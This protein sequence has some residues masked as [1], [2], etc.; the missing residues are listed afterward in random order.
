M[1]AAEELLQERL[2]AEELA[3][4]RYLKGELTQ[5]EIAEGVSEYEKVF[6]GGKF[7]DIYNF[8]QTD[9]GQEVALIG[10]IYGGAFGGA[11][12]PGDI[13]RTNS[14]RRLNNFLNEE[15]VKYS[16]TETTKTSGKYRINPETNELELVP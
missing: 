12:L 14:L 10:G 8:L 15:I 9:Q 2:P 3:Y 1:N 11:S 5:K 13:S 16:A 7:S 6:S 4:N